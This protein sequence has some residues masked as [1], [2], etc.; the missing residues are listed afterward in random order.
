L[1]FGGVGSRW[2]VTTSGTE[3]EIAD[4]LLELE[5]LLELEEFEALEELL[6]VLKL[7]ISRCRASLAFT[8]IKSK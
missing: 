3:S 2:V 4:E 6:A 5:L 8:P 7:R 1:S